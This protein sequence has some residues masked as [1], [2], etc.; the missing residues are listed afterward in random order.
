[1]YD[2][3]LTFASDKHLQQFVRSYLHVFNSIQIK[4][5]LQDI[6]KEELPV[7]ETIASNFSLCEQT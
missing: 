5:Y 7:I 1:M 3:K 2:V 6:L 4:I